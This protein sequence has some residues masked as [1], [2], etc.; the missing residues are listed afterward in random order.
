LLS[1]DI[2]SKFAAQKEDT[3]DLRNIILQTHAENKKRET[4]TLAAMRAIA[5][6]K[7]L[8]QQKFS[9]VLQTQYL[10]KKA[11]EII[12]TS[13]LFHIA[14]HPFGVGPKHSKVLNGE[15]GKHGS[16]GISPRAAPNGTNGQYGRTDGT[17][18]NDGEDG[19]EGEQGLSGEHGDAAPDFQIM[20]D[21]VS[22][23]LKTGKRTYRIEH[24]GPNGKD[25]TTI[26]ISIKN[27]V[28][29]LNGKGG[30]GGQG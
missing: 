29:F 15:N 30:N 7:P 3:N 27:T 13:G 2:S 28:F 4:M 21:L 17:D 12:G 26:N 11:R 6:H 23:D 24:A 10:A 19:H 9:T 5:E 8:V 20:I 1:S 25:E 18:G 14:I 16:S 22:E